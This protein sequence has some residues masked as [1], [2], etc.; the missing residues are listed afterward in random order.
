M[1]N[2]KISESKVIERREVTRDYGFSGVEAIV[3]HAKFG[4]ILLCDGYG[5]KGLSG[6]CVRWEHGLVV[7]LM[8]DDSFEKLD[9]DWNY[10][11]SILDAAC[12]GYDVDR[13]ILNLKGHMIHNMAKSLKL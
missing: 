12:A 5:E 11:N 10:C 1:G 13:K 8:P 2:W 6:G 7:S 9:S 4:R 3:D